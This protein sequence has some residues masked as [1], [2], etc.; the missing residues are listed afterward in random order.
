MKHSHLEE[1]Y[2]N[3]QKTTGVTLPEDIP[4]LPYQNPLAVEELSMTT[5]LEHSEL[6]GG[7]V[8]SRNV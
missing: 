1:C 4:S 3:Y 2:G 7:N 6:E 8:A 5:H